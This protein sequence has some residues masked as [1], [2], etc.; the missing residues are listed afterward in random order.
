MKPMLS[1]LSVCLCFFC[2]AQRTVDV[3]ASDVKVGQN[4]FFV[5]NGTPFVNVKYV[6]LVSGTPYFKEDWM[7]GELVGETGTEYKGLSIKIDLLADQVHYQDAKGVDYITTTPI[8]EIVL[9]DSSKDNYRF[10]HSSYLPQDNSSLKS[11]WYLWLCTG[12]ASLYKAFNKRL[13]E[14]RPYNSATTEQSIASTERYLVLYNNAYLE[15]KKLK[16]APSVLA[17]KKA[18]LEEFLK[19]KDDKN[20]SMDDRFLALINYYNSLFK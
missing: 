7:K 5:V 16:D 10:I 14:Q 2:Q 12:T 3:S 15:I 1:A 4:S 20:S 19:S 18:E 13:T 6:S 17:N 9:T 11:G 8:R